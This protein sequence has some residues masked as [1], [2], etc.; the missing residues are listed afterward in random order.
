M[1]E[2]DAHKTGKINAVVLKFNIFGI[3][4]RMPAIVDA[5][6]QVLCQISRKFALNR[7]W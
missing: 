1:D 6:F 4:R 5:G 3:T 2:K 7:P